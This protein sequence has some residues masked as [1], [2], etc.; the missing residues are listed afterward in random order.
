MK[1]LKAIFIFLLGAGTGAGVSYAFLKR[2][3]ENLADE[4]IESVKK[5]YTVKKQEL[6]E[7][8]VKPPISSFA[9]V[10]ETDGIKEEY[11]KET[12]NYTNYTEFNKAVSSTNK[13]VTP[14]SY[15]DISLIST[16]E[17]A[18]N[19]DE[20]DISTLTYYSGDSVITDDKNIPIDE[21]E[22]AIGTDGIFFFDRNPD[23]SIFYVRNDVLK[24]LYEVC[25]DGR[26]YKD[27]SGYEMR[28]D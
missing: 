25:Y 18:A 10:S 11:T 21:P 15:M 9:N 8:R 12:N 26:C 2:Y 4:E 28:G 1:A 17:F 23:E 22:N 3:F 20:Y 27:V 19:E 13:D 24:C 6:P 14:K 16:E 5:I 7:F